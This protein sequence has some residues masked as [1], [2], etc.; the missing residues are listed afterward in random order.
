MLIICQELAVGLIHSFQGE[1][2]LAVLLLKLLVVVLQVRNT[3]YQVRGLPVPGSNKARKEWERWFHLLQMFKTSYCTDWRWEESLQRTCDA[4]VSSHLLCP[5]IME[6]LQVSF[7]GTKK[8]GFKHFFCSQQL[9]FAVR[10]CHSWM[11]AQEYF[12]ILL[13]ISW[14][15]NEASVFTL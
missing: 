10:K 3:G 1:L 13:I 14:A 6:H 11:S 15:T 7:M 5:G 8:F 9:E 12:K 4:A 2:Q